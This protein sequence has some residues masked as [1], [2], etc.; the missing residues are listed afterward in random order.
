M[1]IAEFKYIFWWEYGHRMF[2]RFI[3]FAFTVPLIYYSARGYIPSNLYKR[4]GV[5]LCLGGSQGMQQQVTLSHP[6]Q[7]KF[8][9]NH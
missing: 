5:L 3:G 4:L 6:T 2:G 9:K 8:S 7:L 1:T